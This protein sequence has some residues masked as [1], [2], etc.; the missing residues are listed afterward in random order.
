MNRLIE[1]IARNFDP[2]PMLNEIEKEY[3]AGVRYMIIAFCV[4]VGVIVY[5][6]VISDVLRWF[7]L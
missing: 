1:W 7:G 4:L 5:G 6:Y 2:A 3:G